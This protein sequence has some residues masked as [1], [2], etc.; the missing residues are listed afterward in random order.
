M[1]MDA[2]AAVKTA[3]EH[4]TDLFGDELHNLLLE[5]LVYDENSKCWD[6]TISFDSRAK[7]ILSPV[8]S[9][10]FSPNPKREYKIVRV[11][12]DGDVQSVKIRRL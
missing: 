9:G 6:V 10:L 7:A 2:K 3:M 4:I 1:G 5:E 11:G 8:P 12:R